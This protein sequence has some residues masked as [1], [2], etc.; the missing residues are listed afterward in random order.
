[1]LSR[2][3]LSIA[4]SCLVAAAPGQFQVDGTF[5][6]DTVLH[7]EAAYF[8]FPPFAQTLPRGT[9]LAPGVTLTAAQY[10]QSATLRTTFASTARGLTAIVDEEMYATGPQRNSL[11]AGAMLDPGVLVDAAYANI[12]AS[13]GSTLTATPRGIAVRIAERGDPG[14]TP[15]RSATVG[16]HDTVLT[17]RAD[18][19][20]LLQFDLEAR[21]VVGPPGTS[22]YT[23]EIDVGDDGSFELIGVPGIRVDCR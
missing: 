8:L 6:A 15:P 21:S 17:L 3:R 5:V 23:A 11:D 19:P 9:N 12:A 1:M 20:R 7:C 16:P 22:T 10:G 2:V 14:Q 4:A 13:F 18:P